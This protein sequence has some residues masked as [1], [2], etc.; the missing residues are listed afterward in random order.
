MTKQQGKTNWMF[1]FIVLAIAVA[2]GAIMLAYIQNTT[3]LLAAPAEVKFVSH[4]KPAQT[5]PPIIQNQTS[6]Q[7]EEI[8][9]APGGSQ[10]TFDEAKQIALA[11]DCAN[12]GVL[13]G[14]YFCNNN[15]GT[16]WINIDVANHPGCAP[17]CVIDVTAKKAE[18]NWRCTGALP[19]Q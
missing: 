11:S 1:I 9:I 18:I 19:P 10:M 6:G 13:K 5:F 2:G 17:A 4:K 12:V 16:W 7:S 3:V 15:T 14:D 8:C